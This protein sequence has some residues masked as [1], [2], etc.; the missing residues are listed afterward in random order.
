MR[1]DEA[2][3]IAI[4]RHDIDSDLGLC[5]GPF[6][7]DHGP[8]HT[9]HPTRDKRRLSRCFWFSRA[10]PERAGEALGDAFCQRPA[11]S[12]TGHPGTGPCAQHG[13]NT[14][15]EKLIGDQVLMHAYAVEMNINPMEAIMTA[16]RRTAALAYEYT[17][18]LAKHPPEEHLPGGEAYNHAVAA[19]RAN[20]DMVK[21]ARIAIDAGA[22]ETMVEQY[23]VEGQA[24]ARILNATLSALCLS[25]AQE[26][27][28]RTIMRRELLAVGSTAPQ[29]V[30][31]LLPEGT[32][33]PEQGPYRPQ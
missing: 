17:E 23:K 29:P 19:R 28:A 6:P 21:Y 1:H 3:Y 2:A 8:N 4:Q 12:G 9:M 7:M 26:L 15:K 18:M 22:R 33:A 13:G 30:L 25:P 27:E 16:V 14:R 32:P 10:G 31:T 11:G 24:I 20:A 5:V